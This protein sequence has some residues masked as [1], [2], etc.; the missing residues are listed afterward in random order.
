M[1][2]HT[3]LWKKASCCWVSAVRARMTFSQSV[4][5]SVGVSKLGVTD[6]IFVDPGGK[7]N[8]VYYRDVFLSQQLLPM[9]RDMSGEFIFQQDSAPAHRARDTVWLTRAS[10]TCFHS[11]RSVAAKQSQPQSSWLQDMEHRSVASV[12]HGCTTLMNLSNVWHGVD[13]TITDNA[14]DEWCVRLHACVRAKG[15]H[16][17]QILC[18]Y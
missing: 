17:E 9:M 10:N 3:I 11:A 1:C 18:Q 6:L 14:T 5:V 12:C 16:F 7:V 13:Q 15:G 8:G 4:M 2:R